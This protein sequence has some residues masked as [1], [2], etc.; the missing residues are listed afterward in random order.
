MKKIITFAVSLVLAAF[1]MCSG[2]CAFALTFNG[3]T[4]AS[5]DGS[6]TTASTGGYSIPTTVVNNTNRAVAYRFSVINKSGQ[7]VKNAVDMF[8]K[9]TRV[10]DDRPYHTYSKFETKYS[11]PYLKANYT[12]LKVPTTTETTGCVYDETWGLYLPEAT[13]GLKAW[14][15]DAHISVI[16][17]KKW[18]IKVSDLEENRWAVLAEPMFPLQIGGANHT[19]TVTEIAAYGASKFGSK[20]D[21]GSSNNSNSW[22]FISNYTNM[23]MPNSLRL[24]K[25]YVGLTA[26]ESKATSRLTFGTIISS[27]YGCAVLYGS[28][29]SLPNQYTLN[30]N[31][32]LDA[33]SKGNTSGYG[34]FDVYINGKLVSDDVTDFSKKLN[35][36]TTYAIKGAK[37]T[38]GHTY[39]GITS[40]SAALSG[41]VKT[42]TT[43]VLS[44][45]TNTYKLNV[46]GLLDGVSKGNTSGYGTF[47]V[48]ID[49][50]L[51]A[52][53][54]T[55]YSATLKYGTA[56][57][58]KDIKAI[59]GHTYNG[60]ASGSSAVSGTVKAAV[61]PVL[62]FSTESYTVD[63]N[64]VINNLIQNNINGY[65]T[66]DVYIDGVL[67]SD[68]VNDFNKKIKYGSKYTVTDIK[69]LGD[70]SYC[71]TVS[72][73]TGLG[74]STGKTF[75]QTAN[76][77][78]GTVSENGV[79]VFLEYAKESGVQIVAVDANAPYKENTDVVTSCWVVNPSETEYIPDSNLKVQMT[80]KSP[81]G[82]E[83]EKQTKSVVVPKI[84]KN[85]CYFKWSVPK[86]HKGENI[87]IVFTAKDDKKEYFE[88]ESEYATQGYDLFEAEDTKFEGK[89]PDDFEVPKE[90]EC[91][92]GYATWWE[93]VYEDNGFVKKQYA[94]GIN[95][96][97]NEKCEAVNSPSAEVKDE[98]LN[99]KSG[100][101]FSL[102]A[103]DE[104]VYYAEN[105]IPKDNMITDCQY[106]SALFPE[107]KY[108]LSAG[109]SETLEKQNGLWQFRKS[110]NKEAVHYTPIYYPD[111]KYT[112]LIQKSDFWTP[113]GM[114]TSKSTS[115][116]NIEDSVYSDWYISHK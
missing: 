57:V 107:Y 33:V 113:S 20:S 22:S 38:A 52:N 73:I 56:Y 84:D 10:G 66:F 76:E 25:T 44:F 95:A 85:L 18:S 93:Y 55:D 92:I 74:N 78:S 46:N 39:N 86:G 7:T 70:A 58:I 109:K 11:K 65:G 12:K 8:R 88:T 106:V 59:T 29:L 79:Y 81:N 63:V 1:F 6:S 48:Y 17:S 89:A 31:G 4:S 98:M 71:G 94:V 40:S 35:E 30:V 111:G 96:I 105:E 82:E 9:A 110:E 5:G 101:G 26:V 80:V 91:D 112:V 99:I 47:D 41:T 97:E 100:Y 50:E 83:I 15:T 13:T 114:V 43:V 42:N 62:S 115:K 45:T 102:S 72:D 90:P 27:G 108:I 14:C 77:L 104:K 34:T 19:L 23:H 87:S 67:D 64:G 28:Y 3:T 32:Y 61:T 16:L 24:T 60:L 103:G 116:M 53:N 21:G 2:L 75:P 51:K 37:V 49:K 69:A 68:D 36:G 54:V